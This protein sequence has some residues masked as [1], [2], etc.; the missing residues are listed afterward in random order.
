MVGKKS[1]LAG[2]LCL[3]ILLTSCRQKPSEPVAT[4]Q[5]DPAAFDGAKALEEV[6]SL[7]ALGPRDSATPGAEAAAKHLRDRLQAMGVEASIDEFKMQSPKGDVAFRNV[8]G[9]LPGGGKGLVILASH[10]DT[11]SGIGEKF[12]GANDSGSSSG[13]LLELARVMAQGPELPFEVMFAFFDGEECMEHYGPSDGLHGSRHL[14]KKL[15][16]EGRGADIRAMILMDMI[17]DRDLTV[18]IPRNST[19]ALIAM[20]FDAAREDGSRTKFSLSN[21]QIG[22]DHDP[23]FSAGIPAIDIIDFYFGSAP[24]RNDYWHTDAD[25][26]DKLSAESLG[27]VGRVVLR[28]VNK[29]AAAP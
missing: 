27:T 11:K 12:Q 14:A 23:F 7:I 24:G 2:I 3:A 22:D 15:I 17:G 4:P 10:Y 29:L 8:M 21:L 6:R 18:T 5:L 9:R 20:A 28:M 13:A 26:M 16:D 1:L 19:P 25:T